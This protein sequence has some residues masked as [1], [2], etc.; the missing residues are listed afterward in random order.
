MQS[1]EGSDG[2]DG[3]DNVAQV[4]RNVGIF[5]RD[6]SETQLTGQK[7]RRTAL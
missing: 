2:V 6:Q 3:H 4:A 1:L 7:R 5:C